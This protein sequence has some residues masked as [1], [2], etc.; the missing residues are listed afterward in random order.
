MRPISILILGS[1][2]ALFAGGCVAPPAAS[3]MWE[4]FETTNASDRDRAIF[5]RSQA[6]AASTNKTWGWI[7]TSAAGAATIALGLITAQNNHLDRR[8]H[9]DAPWEATLSITIVGAIAT[10]V[11]AWWSWGE[12]SSEGD[13]RE[14]ERRLA[15]AMPPEPPAEKPAA[16]PAE[17]PTKQPGGKAA[18][19]PAGKPV[20]KPADKPAEKPADNPGKTDGAPPAKPGSGG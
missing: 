5:A 16:K 9:W 17:E 1:A 3:E 15:H 8:D 20:T 13:W 18:A 12:Q 14:I 6:D 4:S 7:G 10:A 11:G 19:K 2:T